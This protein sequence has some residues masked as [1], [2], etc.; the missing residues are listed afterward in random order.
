[1]LICVEVTKCVKFQVPR[2]KGFK[3]GIFR[4]SPMRICSRKCLFALGISMA[5]FLDLFIKCLVK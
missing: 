1:M 2:Y 4:I 3:V 5:V